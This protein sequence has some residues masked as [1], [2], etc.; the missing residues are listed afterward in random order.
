[1]MWLMR[2]FAWALVLLPLAF[3]VAACENA[4][5]NAADAVEDTGE[6]VFD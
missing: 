2:R 3:T 1:M 4:A 5:E 6:E